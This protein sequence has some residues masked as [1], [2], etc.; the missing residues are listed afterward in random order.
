MSMLKS[1]LGAAVVILVSSSAASA[2]EFRFDRDAL[3][4]SSGVA[5][6]ARSI[7]RFAESACGMKAGRRIGLQTRLAGEKCKA[8]VTEDIVSKIGDSRLEAAVSQRQQLAKN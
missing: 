3:N 2:L 1:F 4:Y 6:T 5:S 8:Q 7:E